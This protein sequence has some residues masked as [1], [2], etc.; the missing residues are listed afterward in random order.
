MRRTKA[1][2]HWQRAHDPAAGLLTAWFRPE[3]SDEFAEGVLFDTG[4]IR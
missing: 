3:L 1:Y 4:Y 2:M